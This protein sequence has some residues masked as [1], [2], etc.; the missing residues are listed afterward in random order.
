MH[1][2]EIQPTRKVC[3]LKDATFEYYEDDLSDTV[4]VDG[5]TLSLVSGR[6]R[7]NLYT[8]KPSLQRKCMMRLKRSSKTQWPMFG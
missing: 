7:K 8:T 4:I 6:V 3:L 1:L 2:N 5:L